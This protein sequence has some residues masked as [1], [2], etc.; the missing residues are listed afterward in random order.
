MESMGY[1]FPDFHGSQ[2]LLAFGE[3][4]QLFIHISLPVETLSPT[5]GPE[6]TKHPIFLLSPPSYPAIVLLMKLPSPSMGVLRKT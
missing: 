2:D 4:R 3:T 1:F 5:N 6:Q